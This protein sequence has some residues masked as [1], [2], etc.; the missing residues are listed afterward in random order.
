M[1]MIGKKSY[2]SFLQPVNLATEEP[3]AELQNM[4]LQEALLYAECIMQQ[5]TL[6][7]IV[8]MVWKLQTKQ[9]EV[10]TFSF[11]IGQ[12][13]EPLPLMEI[14]EEGIRHSLSSEEAE[15]VLHIL[16]FQYKAKEKEYEAP[17][18]W[19][20]ENEENFYFM[21]SEQAYAVDHASDRE[22]VNVET[23]PEISH[24]ETIQEPEIALQEDVEEQE[25]ILN[26]D[27][28]TLEDNN[29]IEDT[30]PILEDEI[31][32]EPNVEVSFQDET[33]EINTKGL[34]QKLPRVDEKLQG[35][36]SSYTDEHATGTIFERHQSLATQKEVQKSID[37]IKKE[38]SQK[39]VQLEQAFWQ[40]KRNLEKQEQEKQKQEEEKQSKQLDILEETYAEKIEQKKAGIQE[41]KKQEKEQALTIEEQKFQ[42]RVLELEKKYANEA[43][44]LANQVAEKLEKELQDEKNKIISHNTFERKQQ[45]QEAIQSI[46][47]L[48]QQKN[49]ESHSELQSYIYELVE[50][51]KVR[52][53]QA[54]ND[55]KPS[56]DEAAKYELEEMKL[57][58][59]AESDE[60]YA[61]LERDMRMKQ[62]EQEKV[63]EDRKQRAHEK[64]AAD[65][66]KHE[67]YRSKEEYTNAIQLVEQM[68][69]LL[70]ID[71]SPRNVV[72]VSESSPSKR[73]IDR[74]FFLFVTVLCACV[75]GLGLYL[76]LKASADQVEVQ[77]V[78]PQM[79][80]NTAA[81]E[82]K[83]VSLDALLNQ[84]EYVKAAEV[85]PTALNQIE[86]AIM[87]SK[88]LS[89]LQRFQDVYPTIFGAL[90]EAILKEDYEKQIQ[91]YEAKPALSYQDY[92]LQA[93]QEAYE[94]LKQPE[95]AKAIRTEH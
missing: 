17:R 80:E 1:V 16:P 48:L 68:T 45:M 61:K 31:V 71:G 26:S 44:D 2:I 47:V 75:I 41:E 9:G 28:I 81:S 15:K 54:I 43:H 3:F 55:I 46:P 34:Y 40:E 7:E 93:I 27:D 21:E 42:Q 39:E 12:I 64:Q 50:E 60:R 6:G 65:Q 70:P 30:V 84:K 94:K 72:S 69:K 53:D 83:E 85:Y 86:A 11:Q 38:I 92:Q 5:L 73:W 33:I 20:L 62:L 35:V 74:C 25:D 59:E 32:A 88:D 82:G 36:F 87:T 89:A 22:C 19:V 63:L 91:F 52:I 14:M 49:N 13:G 18:Q 58:M 76:G 56:L 66:M 10:Y 79:P 4:R 67:I 37:R 90:D 77:T 78:T 29:E 8:S 51:E 23:F 24:T 57:R 95:K